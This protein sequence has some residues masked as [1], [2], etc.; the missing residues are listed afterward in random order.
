[1][2]EV[3]IMEIIEKVL[4]EYHKENIKHVLP[5]YGMDVPEDPK[6]LLTEL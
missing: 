5:S 2:D 6:T 4:Q 3:N 1:M